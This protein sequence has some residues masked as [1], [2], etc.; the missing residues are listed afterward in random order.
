MEALD[1]IGRFKRIWRELMAIYVEEG[2]LPDVTP[3]TEVDFILDQID[4]S[5]QI[6]S[7]Y[8][9]TH[10]GTIQIASLTDGVGSTSA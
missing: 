2:D 4:I 7:S 1:L 3:I 8:I 6:L 10:G 5:V 9:E